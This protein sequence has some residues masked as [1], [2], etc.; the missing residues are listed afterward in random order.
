MLYLAMQGQDMLERPVHTALYRLDFGQQ[1]LD[2]A[3]RFRLT[4]QDGH[5]S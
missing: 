5:N 1:L 4:A 3:D 2:F